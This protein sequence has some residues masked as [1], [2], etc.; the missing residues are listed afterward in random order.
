M[1]ALSS[2]P[3][4]LERVAG[5][6]IM[7]PSGLMG[8]LDPKHEY[9]VVWM[10]RP[11]AEIL[12]GQFPQEAGGVMI[13]AEERDALMNRLER[14]VQLLQRVLRER[15]QVELLEV[16]HE[17]MRQDP[18]RIMERLAAFFGDELTGSSEAMREVLDRLAGA[19]A[20]TISGNPQSG[21]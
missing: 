21:T 10:K 8:Q 19:A 13:P 1:H 9:R 20:E 7:I 5:R 2:D 17:Q 18:D 14:H 12:H 15:P 3:R 4:V 16:D 11:V 6:V